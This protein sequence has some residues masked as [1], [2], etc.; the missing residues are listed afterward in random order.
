[1]IGEMIM[2]KV[3]IYSSIIKLFFLFAILCPVYGEPIIINQVDI[4]G[5]DVSLAL[6]Y[7][8]AKFK[9]KLPEKQKEIWK[10]YKVSFWIEEYRSGMKIPFKKDQLYEG[11]IGKGGNGHFLTKMP[12]DKD[13][14]Y[15]IVILGFS[16][17]MTDNTLLLANA[18]ETKIEFSNPMGAVSWHFLQKDSIK[19]GIDILLGLRIEGYPKFNPNINELLN[20]NIDN[21]DLRL[22]AIKCRIDN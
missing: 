11:G 6:G 3:I 1:M 2:K 8:I 10:N 18:G 19:F 21:S 13:N 4:D 17:N 9:V 16:K 20:N 7:K 14:S 12:T 15:N 5:K 22:I